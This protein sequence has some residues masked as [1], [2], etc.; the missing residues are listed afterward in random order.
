MAARCRRGSGSRD[1][2]GRRATSDR[3]ANDHYGDDGHAAHHHTAGN[4]PYDSNRDVDDAE[5][6]RGEHGGGIRVQDQIRAQEDTPPSTQAPPCSHRRR[7]CE[8]TSRRRECPPDW[9]RRDGRV[10]FE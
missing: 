3:D 2:A 6:R 9:W 8:E 1:P 4:D 10:R 7:R 5:H